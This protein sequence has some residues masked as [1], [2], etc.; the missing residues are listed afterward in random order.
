MLIRWD[1]AS[2]SLNL[3]WGHGAFRVPDC[4]ICPVSFGIFWACWFLGVNVQH[5]SSTCMVYVMENANLIAGW[6]VPGGT[7]IFG[8]KN[9]VGL[10]SSIFSFPTR[11]THFRF[12][13]FQR[14]ILIQGSRLNQTVK[15]GGFHSH[16][17]T[18]IAGWFIM[19]YPTKMDD[20]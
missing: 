17:G 5:V 15:Y 6:W 4:A 2:R 3:L 11:R 12:L 19:E 8:H 20:D 16:G 18:P 10:L 9:H 13:G 7:P 1:I 14:L